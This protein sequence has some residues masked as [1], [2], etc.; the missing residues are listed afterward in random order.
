MPHVVWR[1]KFRVG[2]RMVECYQLSDGSRLIEEKSLH[3]LVAYLVVHTS[4]T[5]HGQALEF[6]NWQQGRLN[7]V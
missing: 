4:L 3:A 5:E 1:G 7:F 6:V 2:T